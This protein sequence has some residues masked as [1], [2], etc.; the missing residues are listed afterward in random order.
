MP[1]TYKI[2]ESAFVRALDPNLRTYISN[3]LAERDKRFKDQ[4]AEH[5]KKFKDKFTQEVSRQLTIRRLEKTQ[6]QIDAKTS[7]DGYSTR[8]YRSS[9]L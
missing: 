3:F 5:D 7:T 9:C 6:N 4:L 2:G 8:R 1:A